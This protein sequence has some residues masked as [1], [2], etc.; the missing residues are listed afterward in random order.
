MAVVKT[1]IVVQ[2]TTADGGGHLSAEIDSRPEGYNKGITS[3]APGDSPAFLVFKSSNVTIV[4]VEPSAGTITTLAGGS[5]LV[6]EM[7]HFPKETEASLQKPISG[8]LASKWLGNDLGTVIVVGDLKVRVANTGVGVL[9]A[10]YNSAFL[11]YRLGG[12]PVKLDG[13][14]NYEVLILITGEQT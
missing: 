8:A 3:F 14:S 5:L 1:S 2:F 4:S 13:E 6:E 11:A 12:L 9:K 7:M 10:S